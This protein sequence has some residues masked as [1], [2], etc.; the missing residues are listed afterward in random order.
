MSK[1]HEI[2][3]ASWSVELFV[4]GLFSVLTSSNSRSFSEAGGEIARAGT[5][6]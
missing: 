4:T 6:L 5:E 2:T 1:C 3:S